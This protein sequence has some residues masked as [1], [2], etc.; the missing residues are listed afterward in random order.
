MGKEF[1]P[2]VMGMVA[3][4]TNPTDF[5]K[6]KYTKEEV[7]N[8]IADLKR[9]N[10]EM[11]KRAREAGTKLVKQEKIVTDSDASKSKSAVQ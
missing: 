11:A 4:Y 9:K 6:H 1:F 5:L 10:M 8:R 2:E 3:A 7:D